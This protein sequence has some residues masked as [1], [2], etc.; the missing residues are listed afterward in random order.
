MTIREGR[1]HA[2]GLE[3]AYLEAGEG[4]LALCL[5]GFPDSARTW[6]HLLPALADAGFRAVA[7]WLRG[8]APTEIPGDGAYQAGALAADAVALHEAL[9][10][11]ERA[12]IVGHDWGA[13]A[14]YAA[15]AA[16]P[17]RWRRVVAMAIPPAGGAATFAANYDQIKRSFYVFFFQ[18]PLADAAVPSHDLRFIEELW[19]DWSPGYDGAEDVAHAK[20]AL[21]EPANLTAAIGYY[22]AIFDPPRA[23]PKNADHQQAS[24][25][26]APQ[27]TLYLHGI[28]D[29]CIGVE[30]SKG[31][32]GAMGPG[33]RV[34]LVERAGHFLHVEKPAEVNGLI[35]DWLTS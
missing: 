18:S 27:P 7:P 14:T 9:G 5:H 16:A 34:Q 33:S 11:D 3:F 26:P 2:N 25:G 24:A 6:R 4:P 29:G 32:E 13:V 20:D 22:R 30:L 21:R 1:V 8:Y 23:G 28:N 31:A 17:G 15:A 12:V 35:A 19:R 10:G